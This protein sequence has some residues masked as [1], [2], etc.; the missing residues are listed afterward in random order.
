MGRKSFRSQPAARAFPAFRR[1]YFMQGGAEKVARKGGERKKRLTH[2][3]QV[4]AFSAG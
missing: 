4:D 2:I 1:V 3:P